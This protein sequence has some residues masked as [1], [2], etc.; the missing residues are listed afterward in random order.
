MQSSLTLP[1]LVA[2]RPTGVMFFST[3]AAGAYR[4]EHE[5]FLR[6]IVGHIAIAVERTRLMDALREK[7]DYLENI[8]HNSA[9]AIVV[10]DSQGRVR[11][12]NEG[13]RQLF[14]F[15]AGELLGRDEVVLVPP[16]GKADLDAMNARLEQAGVVRGHE[17]VRLAKDGRRLRVELTATLLRDKH[18]RPAGRSFIIRDVT[19]VRRLQQEL[20]TSQSLAAVGELAATVAHEIKNPLAGISGAIQVL[21]DGTAAGDPRREIMGEILD[22]IRRL[23]R[24]VRDLLEFARPATASKEPMDLGDSLRR[25][26]SLL[27]QAPGAKSVTLRLDVPKDLVIRADLQ[28]LHQVWV[29]LFQNAIEAMPKGGEVSV[30]ARPTPLAVEVEVQDGGAGIDPATL[31][32]IFKPFYTTKTRGTGLGLPITRKIIEAHGGRIRAESEPG[33]RTS[34]YVE[35]PR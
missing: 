9:D 26:W 17:C 29:N 18:G 13:A 2:G 25:A 27:S 31:E 24:T 3:R 7:G 32:R 21:A 22:Q 19:D 6:A 14:G 23:D 16:E 28:L 34:F 5:E 20:L 8:L 12:W 30:S 11:A 1:L 15:D 33:K 10:T 4:P 35:I